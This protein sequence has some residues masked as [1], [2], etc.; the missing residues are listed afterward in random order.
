M[1]NIRITERQADIIYSML[2]LWIN[3]GKG[4]LSAKRRKIRIDEL[5]ELEM[6]VE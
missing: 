1:R 6:K 3:S 4:F 2:Q 5:E